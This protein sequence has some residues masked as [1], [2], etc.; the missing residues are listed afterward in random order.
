MLN[1]IEVVAG[2]NVDAG[3]AAIPDQVLVQ[4]AINVSKL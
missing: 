1:D 3:I 2:D 4:V